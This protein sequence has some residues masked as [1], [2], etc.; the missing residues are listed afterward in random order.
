M[1]WATSIGS[2]LY[3]KNCFAFALGVRELFVGKNCVTETRIPPKPCLTSMAC[4]WERRPEVKLAEGEIASVFKLVVLMTTWTKAGRR[5]RLQRKC[6]RLWRGM[7]LA[8]KKELTIRKPK[9]SKEH[10]PFLLTKWLIQIRKILE[11][12]LVN[13][14]KI[15]KWISGRRRQQHNPTW[16]L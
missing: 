8:W 4:G 3:S 14:Q 15:R 10:R 6:R 1:S 7:F 16:A 5:K 13:D 11:V 12:C 2:L 9:R